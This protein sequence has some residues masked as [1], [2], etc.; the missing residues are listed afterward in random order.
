MRA[1]IRATG[2]IQRPDPAAEVVGQRVTVLIA[3]C[4]SDDGLGVVELAVTKI[5]NAI[6]NLVLAIGEMLFEPA[7]EKGSDRPRQPQYD[8]AR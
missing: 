3:M 2:R 5:A 1:A 7:L 6:E 4:R 8:E